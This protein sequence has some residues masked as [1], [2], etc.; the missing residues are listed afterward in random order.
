MGAQTYVRAADP[1]SIRPVPSIFPTIWQAVRIAA[2]RI[3]NAGMLHPDAA[4][5]PL[6]LCISGAKQ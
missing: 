5:K 1:T 2:A 4:A 6:A 3:S